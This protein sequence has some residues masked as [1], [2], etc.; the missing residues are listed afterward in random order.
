MTFTTQPELLHQFER[1]VGASLEDMRIVTDVH[2]AACCNAAGA[3]ALTVGNTI[4]VHPAA[5]ALPE[6]AYRELIAHEVIH[7]VQNRRAA[8]RHRRPQRTLSTASD[9]AEREA[10]RLAVRLA[11]GQPVRVRATPVAV[12][13]RATMDN[14]KSY[15]PPQVYNDIAPI[16]RDKTGGERDHAINFCYALADTFTELQS[17]V[18]EANAPLGDVG[19]F[20]TFFVNSKLGKSAGV[21]DRNVRAANDWVAEIKGACHGRGMSKA[22]I[23]I[24]L[25]AAAKR[26]WQSS[27]LRKVFEDSEGSIGIGD[28]TYPRIARWMYN[29]AFYHRGELTDGKMRVTGDKS[30]NVHTGHGTRSVMLYKNRIK[31]VIDGHTFRYYVLDD[32]Q[33]SNLMRSSSGIQSFYP[34]HYTDLDVATDVESAVLN[35]AQAKQALHAG[36]SQFFTASAPYHLRM[37]FNYSGAGNA[38]LGTA[39]PSEQLGQQNAHR[40]PQTV[41]QSIYSLMAQG[42][43]LRTLRDVLRG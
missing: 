19:V 15:L 1:A 38:R 40:I 7:V 25:L 37:S 32:D 39:Y 3:L 26:N 22:D 11:A 43:G 12:V 5:S 41:L 20:S 2:A 16:I 36:S 4:L 13:Q 24:L 27:Q 33:V 23:G 34:V 30:V 42:L 17:Y 14:L 28:A 31:H 9:A 21:L 18:Q 35:A 8:H 29:F 10:R 6:M